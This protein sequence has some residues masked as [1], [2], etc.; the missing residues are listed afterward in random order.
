MHH[1]AM[2]LIY[3]PP[4][5]HKKIKLASL[6]WLVSKADMRLMRLELSLALTTIVHVGYSRIPFACRYWANCKAKLGYFLTS[7]ASF[8]DIVRSLRTFDIA[9]GV[10]LLRAFGV[11]MAPRVFFSILF[12]LYSAAFVCYESLRHTAAVYTLLA[13]PILVYLEQSLVNNVMLE[14]FLTR[15]FVDFSRRPRFVMLFGF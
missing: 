15:L 8:C 9:S 10:L 11:R 1:V 14:K 7:R 4:P 13:F 12:P 2:T 3:P 5:P 6:L